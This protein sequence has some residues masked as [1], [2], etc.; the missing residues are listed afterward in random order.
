MD[1]SRNRR[2]LAWIVG[3]AVVVAALGFVGV[4]YIYIHF[5]DKTQAPLSVNTA[6]T[7]SSA[8]GG[9]TTSTSVDGTWTVASGS[10][11]GYRV[12]EVLDGHS[13]TA[14]GR[15]A[16][17]TGSLTVSGG[18]VVTGTFSADM[19]TVTSDQQQRDGQFR[20]RI[21]DTASYPVATFA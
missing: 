14:T 8:T 21:M 9:S 19:D 18:S 20:G 7:P 4:P 1:L 3:G 2:R 10:T 17:I 6:A 13:H 5:I 12:N 16:N 15:T 11:A